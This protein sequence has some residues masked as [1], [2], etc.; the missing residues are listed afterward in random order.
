MVISP[1]VSNQA[2]FAKAR[3]WILLHPYWTLT[4]IVL[5][6]LV[7]FLGK[8]FNID[9]PLFIWAA[10]QIQANPA[11]PYGFPVEWGWTQFPM[12]KVTENPPLAAYYL[13][14]AAGI[15]G[16]SEVA[17]H[18]AFLVP[19]LAAV[20]GT[21][22]LA[23]RLCHQPMLATLIMLFTP[24]FLVSSLTLMCD[25]SML[26]F[27]IW[28]VIFWLEGTGQEKNW[29]LLVAAAL[30]TLAELTKYYGACLVPLLAAY[31]LVA[32][33][34]L[35]R[36]AYHLLLPLAALLAYQLV[37]QALYGKSLLYGAMDY[38]TFSRTFFGFSTAQNSL[39]GLVFTGGCV[40]AAVIFAPLLWRGRTL[41]LFFGIAIAVVLLLFSG[42]AFWKK[43]GAISGATQMAV[44]IQAMLWSAAGLSLLALAIAEIRQ[45]RDALSC[46]LTLWLLGTFAFATFLNWTINARSILPMT[47]AAGMLI[48][49]RLE[50]KNIFKGEF[51]SPGIICCLAISMVLS[52]SVLRAD[53]LTAFA[54]RTNAREACDSFR[55]RVGTLWF[56]GHWGFQFY[57]DQGGATA[58][59]AKR[60]D[61]KPGDAVAVPSSN[62]NIRLLDPRY[63]ELVGVHKVPGPWLATTTE[64]S[65]G[66]SFYASAFGPLPFAFGWVPPETVSVFVLKPMPAAS[67]S[68]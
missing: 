27:W 37:T 65:M 18:A 60:S 62:T 19:V 67:H 20:L 23:R 44:K 54:V 15:I 3:H 11:N 43:Y 51:W 8:P 16:W 57:M 41:A 26:A 55:Q 48:A 42:E 12:W 35:I 2:G 32:R 66:A 29:K 53:Y 33:R 64:Q 58:L 68:P 61:L 13:A 24:V 46:L 10:H 6:V 7:P 39:I 4:G 47:P 34:P 52:V 1:T 22:R 36:W 21:Y 25:M 59:D 56:Q 30:I 49:R 63:A 31:S 45:R 9:D 40:A 5:A 38:S 28:A 50:M 17:L 14:A